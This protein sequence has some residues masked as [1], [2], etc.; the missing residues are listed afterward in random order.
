MTNGSFSQI[1]EL[2]RNVELPMPRLHPQ[3][4]EVILEAIH[5]AFGGLRI[6]RPGDLKTGPEKDLNAFLVSRLNNLVVEVDPRDIS[7]QSSWK[8][9]WQQLVSDVSR[10]N[11]THNYNAEHLEY[12]PDLNL[13]L[14]SGH[15]SFPLVGECKLIDH[16]SGKTIALY[17]VNGVDRFR[18]GAYA[19]ALR[20]ALMVAYV[21][22]GSSLENALTPMLLPL[23]GGR[24]MS[25]T[26]LPILTNPDI[27]AATSLHERAF[28]YPTRSPPEDMPGDITLWHVWV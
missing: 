11:E 14:T 8:V 24:A 22:D 13:T 4:A 5:N 18:N 26:M 1:E 2:T 19:W 21:R 28:T 25:A 23:G 27:Q 10:G 9:L 20:D 7:E 3:H 12:R 6:D 16:F 17:H 15:P